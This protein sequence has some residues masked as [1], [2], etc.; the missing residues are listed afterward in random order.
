MEIKTKIDK[1]NRIRK[2][3]VIGLMTREEFVSKLAEIYSGSEGNKDMHVLWD[4]RE[5]DLSPITSGEV[6][7]IKNFVAR[8][9]ATGGSYRAA[10]VVSGDLSYGIS[11]MFSS[12]LENVSPNLI[13][14][15]RDYKKAVYWLEY[16]P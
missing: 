1:K 8:H 11:R 2:H 12:L 16:G 6:L 7:E 14:V 15:L 10:I 9:W 5:A 3:K 4:L 13:F